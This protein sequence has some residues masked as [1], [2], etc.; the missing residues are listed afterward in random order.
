MRR[1]E[2]AF[3]SLLHS[4]LLCAEVYFLLCSLTL[5][6]SIQLFSCAG[7]SEMKLGNIVQHIRSGNSYKDK[8]Q[9]LEEIGFKYKVR[10]KKD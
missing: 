2:N 9:E 6:H 3:H 5:T 1:D 7:I 8:R 10:G 4:I